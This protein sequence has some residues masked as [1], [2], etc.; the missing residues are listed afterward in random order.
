MVPSLL[1]ERKWDCAETVELTKWTRTLAE[2]CDKLPPSAIDNGSDVPLK[3]VFF[4]TNVLRHM[5]VHQ[6]LTTAR[7]PCM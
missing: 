3:E 1:E 2:R 7:G 6:L 5:A 4:S